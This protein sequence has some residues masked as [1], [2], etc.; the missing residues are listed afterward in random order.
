MNQSETSLKVYDQIIF[1]LEKLPSDT[2]QT[3]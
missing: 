1:L 3:I 2:K